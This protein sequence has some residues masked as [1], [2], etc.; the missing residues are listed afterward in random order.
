MN[1]K[2]RS[3]LIG[4]GIALGCCAA[5]AL[6][7]HL[8]GLWIGQRVTSS[9]YLIAVIVAARF[10]GLGPALLASVIGFGFVWY[11]QTTLSSR[12]TSTHYFLAF[13]Y[14]ALA[15]ILTAVMELERR[16]R[17]RAADFEARLLLALEAGRM[18]YWD[19]N[20][21]TNRVRS[22][23][24]Q[25]RLH[26]RAPH[27]T[28]TDIRDSGDNIHPDDRRI[29]QDAIQRAMRNEAHDRTAYRV[30]LPDGTVRWIEAVGRVFCDAAG[31]PR[32]VMGVC[33][34]ITEHRNAERRF[35][36]IYEQAP[37]GIGIVD[38]RS[39]A[40]L[41]INRRYEQIIG[42]S[43]EEMR[44]LTFQE[45]THPDDLTDDL[46]NMSK[47]RD[48]KIRRFE[49]QKR[50]LKGDGSYMWANLTVVPFWQVGEQVTSH[51]AMIEDITDRKNAED[52]L[53]AREAQLTGILDNT[54]AVV[55]LKDAEGR[56]LL[57]NKRY[58]NLFND[59][60]SKLIG[61]RDHDIFPEQVARTFVES[62]Q[63]VWR[64]QTPHDF[65]EVAPHADGLH[66]YRS[67]KFPVRDETGRMIALGG[68]STDVTDLKIAHQELLAKQSLLR[69]LIEV[70]EDEKQFLCREFHDGLIQYAVGS[71]MQLESR[72]ELLTGP[73]AKTIRLVIDNLRR[74]VEDGR[75]TI[76]G[77]RPAV[78]DDSGLEAAIDDLLGQFESSG[79][80]VTSKCDGPI[81][82]L[83]E[84][85]QTTVYRV[86]QEALNNAKKYSGT[87]VIRIE[88]R[89]ADGDLR[90]EVRD[91]GC[92]F[93]VEASRPRG[94]GLR[95]MTERVRLLG[96]DCVIESERD[97]GTTISVRIPLTGDDDE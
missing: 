24:T 47:L 32:Q 20:L 2:L 51:M 1:P 34:D 37:L 10:G 22:S 9:F 3:A 97:S 6:A 73:A 42:R 63:I 78:L 80:L 79:I 12:F 75:R 76:R 74:G 18:G 62:D 17:R 48:G 36:D 43:E 45:I 90:L 77:I 21:A 68:I 66:T 5:A 56:Y 39:G 38:S 70:Q 64:E 81:G 86:V 52:K 91:F 25:A 54:T 33:T 41:Q 15:M 87:D 30:V 84:T 49:M 23:E 44:R 88:M 59:P 53:R 7:F 19:W 82:R 26:G 13:I 58:R 57:T 96:G 11:Q 8:T 29:V 71:L 60:D 14:F 83:S 67:V 69:N 28:E 89:Q 16:A 92:G 61:K 31:K 65:E 35:R 93:D 94:F 85:V 46:D 95:G 50:L 4:Y 27:E 40:F 55:Y 72:P